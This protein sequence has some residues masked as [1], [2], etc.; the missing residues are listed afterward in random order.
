MATPSLESALAATR[1]YVQEHASLRDALAAATPGAVVVVEDRNDHLA[2]WRLVRLL[3]TDKENEEEAWRLCDK[4]GLV[5]NEPGDGC[6]ASGFSNV[7]YY[8]RQPDPTLA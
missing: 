7:R 4:D 3:R 2:A 6:P 8:R 1:V 5:L